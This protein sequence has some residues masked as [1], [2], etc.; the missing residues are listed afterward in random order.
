MQLWDEVNGLGSTISNS[1]Q[2]TI[3]MDKESKHSKIWKRINYSVKELMAMPL[4]DLVRLSFTKLKWKE[5]W[6]SIKQDQL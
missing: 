2:T 3:Q 1:L 5:S 4:E 6:S